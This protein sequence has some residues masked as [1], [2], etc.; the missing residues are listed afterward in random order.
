MEYV[1]FG[2]SGLR[3]SEVALGAL[4]FGTSWGDAGVDEAESHRVM[5]TFAEAGGNFIDTADIYTEGE[6]EEIVGRFVA[7][8]RDWWVIASKFSGS[9]GLD[10]DRG[11]RPH[12]NS[13]GN[14]RKNMNRAVEA[15]LRRLGTD[16][17]DVYY[18]HFWDFMTLPE[19]VMKGIDD[20]VGAGKILYPAFSD[21]PAWIVSESNTLARMHGWSPAVAIQVEYSLVERSAER[22]LF[23]MAQ[24]HDLAIVPWRVLAGGLLAGP[25]ATNLAADA[26]PPGERE[27]VIIAEADAVADELGAT[28]AQV[29]WAW[30]RSRGG[31]GPMVP[32]IGARTADQL[33]SNL[34]GMELKL[35]ASQLARLV[36]A[37][38]TP[39]GFPMKML[40]DPENVPRKAVGGY[41]HRVHNHRRCPHPDE[42][43]SRTR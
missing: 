2:R 37:S 17:I 30:V 29:A 12:P 43:M 40:L 28:R 4:T 11:F 5:Q 13:G 23:P 32:L 14:H 16:H 26:R 36:E 38:S 25:N 21:T 19:E 8:D 39:L 7:S 42:P 15:S 22:E 33:K 20:L 34:A 24:A 27:A 3:V 31:W 35:E 1:I 18:L 41:Q 6:S 10:G 9:L